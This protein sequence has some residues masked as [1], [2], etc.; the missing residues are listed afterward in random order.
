MDNLELIAQAREEL[1]KEVALIDSWLEGTETG[2][3]WTSQ[4]TK[5]KVI[6]TRR[7]LT[8]HLAEMYEHK[9]NNG[10]CSSSRCY[11]DCHDGEGLGCDDL[12]HKFDFYPC[13]FL[14]TKAKRLLGVTT[15]A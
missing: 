2:E 4:D 10:R 5:D 3:F 11:N 6:W 7:T 14:L 15:D 1:M 9:D 13:D 12:C 8:I